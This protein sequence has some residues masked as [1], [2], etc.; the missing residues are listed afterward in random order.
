MSNL[1]QLTPSNVRELSCVK[2][3]KTLRIDKNW[4]RR[5]SNRSAQF[6]SGWHKVMMHVFDPR[7]GAGPH[8]EDLSAEIRD[9][10]AVVSYAS[11]IERQ[12]AWERCERMV[13]G[14]VEWERDDPS[15]TIATEK[16]GKFA[17]FHAGEPLYEVFGR[18]DRILV[19][20]DQPDVLVVRDAKLFSRECDLFE[21]FLTLLT[22]KCMYPAYKRYVLE[23]DTISEDAEVRREIITSADVKG[24]HKLVWKRLQRVLNSDAYDAE[25]GDG[26]KFCPLQPT[27]Q[28]AI[29]I[30][31]DASTFD[32]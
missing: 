16:Q 21:G 10:F 6:A 28:P 32:F 31:V 17:F 4:P 15:T 27:C 20:D 13:L 23:I 7:A 8:L 12:E 18:L 26:C 2:R 22:L 11:K 5:T 24:I 1:V 29:E 30:E 9:A 19:R 14:Y 3:F 25:P